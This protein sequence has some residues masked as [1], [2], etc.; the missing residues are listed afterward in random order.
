MDDGAAVYYE[1]LRAATAAELEAAGPRIAA[2]LGRLPAGGY[3]AAG[4]LGG[5]DGPSVRE[6]VSWA[7]SRGIISGT[8]A[9][10]GLL[11]LETVR[12]WL[13]QISPPGASNV[14]GIR[15]T[16]H[17]Y[18]AALGAFDRWL[19][20][21]KFPAADGGGARPFRDIE[22]LLGF[23]AGHAGG[24]A[25]ARRLLRQYLADAAASGCS[26]STALVRCAAV[27]SY[28]AAHDVAV[29]VRVARKRYASRGDWTTR[30]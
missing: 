10:G 20:T 18:A 15:G 21:K 16:R 29:D 25:A 13:S 26:L 24:A 8:T 4:E 23:C 11:G 28:F 12:S 17:A 9:G 6:A 30:G 27:R 19:R 3:A 5:P 22:N 2:V 14:A 7:R 1:V